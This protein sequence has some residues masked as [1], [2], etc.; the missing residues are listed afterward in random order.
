M[1]TLLEQM[2]RKQ[3]I[4][5]ALKWMEKQDMRTKDLLEKFGEL[6]INPI[7][8]RKGYAASRMPSLPEIFSTI[9]EEAISIDLTEW[10]WK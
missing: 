4:D 5:A 10:K 3:T 8:L 7:P 6:G 9:S 1:L 2:Q